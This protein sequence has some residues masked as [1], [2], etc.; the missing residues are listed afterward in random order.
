MSR[1]SWTLHALAEQ[2][3]IE[4]RGPADL[5]LDHLAP[6]GSAQAG[7]LSFL[8][9]PRYRHQ[10]EETQASAVILHPSLAG[11]C[12][13]AMLLSDNPYL[14][15]ARASHLFNRAPIPASGVHQSAVVDETAQF[16]DS[17][18]IGA[19]AVIE[20]GCVLASG[21]VI[22]PGTVV[23]AN[24]VIGENTRLYANVTLYHNVRIGA[25]CIVHSGVVIGSDGFGFANEKGRWVKIAQLGGVVIGDDVDIGACTTIDRGAIGD[26][27]IGNGVILDNLNMIAHNVVVGDHT[28]MAACS[29]ISGSSKVG[30]HC[31]IAGGVGIAG[32][33]EVA[34]R[35][36]LSMCTVVS[37]SLPESGSYS[38]G[39]AISETREWRKNA[40]RFRQLDSMARRLTALERMLDNRHPSRHDEGD[41][42][43]GE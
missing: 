17:V 37:S 30:S 6:L 40:A 26:T 8:A 19:N 18:S 3:G 36:Q 20:A 4:M 5:V 13:A 24:C 2:L 35:V 23:G 39:T 34:D 38:S 11:G 43:A 29:G 41:T 42:G 22:G 9:N 7:A 12:S 33:L 32:H 25:R 27:R 31:I 14:T 10:L 15:Y 21:V 1:A 28:A 16:D